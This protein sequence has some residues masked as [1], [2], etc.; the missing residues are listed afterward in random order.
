MENNVNPFPVTAYWGPAFFCRRKAAVKRLYDN[1]L[2]RVHSTLISIRRM[3]KT[4][5]W[6][7]LFQQLEKRRGCSVCTLTYLP[8]NHKPLS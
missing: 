2:N 8:P 4:A 5:L 3:G 6:K 7:H 1:M